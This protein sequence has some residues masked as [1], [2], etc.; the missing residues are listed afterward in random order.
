MDNVNRKW[1]V[2]CQQAEGCTRGIVSLTD[3]ELIAAKRLLNYEVVV[4]DTWSGGFGITDGPFDTEEEARTAA[5]N[6]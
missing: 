6:G 5:I 1:Y 2:V 3:E 4:E